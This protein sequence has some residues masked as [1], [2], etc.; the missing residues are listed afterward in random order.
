M[1]AVLPSASCRPA[2]AVMY[3]GGARG[4]GSLKGAKR[5]IETYAFPTQPSGPIT[6]VL[7]DEQ[8]MTRSGVRQALE[9]A[10]LE[11]VA[12]ADSGRTGIRAV[13]DLRPEVVLMDPMFQG[14]YSIEAIERI[15]LLA[16]ASRI[17]VLT[18]SKEREILLEAIVAGACGYILKVADAEAIVNAVRAAARGECVISPEV[19]EGLLTR[20][21]ERDTRIT[22]SSK[23]EADA[24][25]ATLTERELEIFTRLAS[26]VSNREIAGAFSLSE[27]TVKNH[28]AS[29]LAKLHLNNRI[30]AA[31]KRS[32]AASLA[33]RPHSYSNRCSTKLIFRAQS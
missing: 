26:G 11:V 12:E 7:V 10:G 4:V 31:A 5:V 30:Q 6:V 28:V 13:V 19:A 22:A 17:L 15:S 24:I 27:S 33:S 14:G 29:I 8:E 20:I 3:A 18:S 25:R 32:A 21:R 16:P 23:R 9:M 2:L 1:W